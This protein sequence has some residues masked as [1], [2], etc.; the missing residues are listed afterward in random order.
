MASQEKGQPKDYDGSTPLKGKD[1][2]FCRE[3]IALDS[4]H[5]GYEKAGFRRARGNA[6]RK[7]RQ[8]NVA[9]RL[10]FLWMEAARLAGV[11]LGRILAEEARL[12]FSNMDDFVRIDAVRHLP[13]LDLSKL[14]KLPE[15][16]RRELMAAVKTIRYTEN[17]PTF[18]LHDKPGTLRDLKKYLGGD[19]PSKLAVMNPDGTPIT[20]AAVPV[21][22]LFGR[23]ESTSAS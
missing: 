18:E 2:I 13:I 21:I 17:G 12:A 11:S 3:A 20:P 19:A 4:I 5:K 7:A 23:P 8:P 10:E 1:E 22:N 9:K 6:D 15:E 16:K 14:E